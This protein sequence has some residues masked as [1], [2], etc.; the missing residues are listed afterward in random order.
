MIRIENV[1]FKHRTT[2]ILTDVSLTIPKGG[3][4]ALIG[5]NG[6][7]KSSLLSLVA[8]L[9]ALQ[10]GTIDIDGLPV[11]TTP[12]RELA[13]VIAILRQDTTVASRLKVRELVGFGRFPHGRGRLTEADHAI[14]D[15][16]IAQFDLAD[17]ADRFIETLSGGQRQRALVAMAF[18][19]GTDYLLLDEPLN[20]LDMYYARELMRSLRSAADGKG[21]TVVIVLHDINQASAHADR[22]VAMKGGRIVADGAPTEILTPEMLETVFGFRMRVETIEG[23]PF[24]LH[25]L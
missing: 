6:A 14:I 25:Q 9:Q 2:P 16:A 3:V 12:G 13:R 7:G 11:D 24:V 20:N 22:I 18:A 19:Q 1:S 15:A 5:P 4:V 17:L 21:K 10:T 23:K 8:R